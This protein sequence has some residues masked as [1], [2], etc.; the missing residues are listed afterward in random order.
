GRKPSG[1][2]TF[3]CFALFPC[4]I[5]AS[6]TFAGLAAAFVIGGLREIGEPARKSLIVDS[7]EPQLRAR[8]VG[9]YY[10]LRCLAIVPAATVG[11]FL[12]KISPRAPFFA[13]GAVGAMAVLVFA[14]GVEERR[15]D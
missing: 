6:T 9:L 1:I 15:G 7:A 10:L 2:A 13:A 11:G 3:V 8:T 4:A 5:A 14:F 12:W